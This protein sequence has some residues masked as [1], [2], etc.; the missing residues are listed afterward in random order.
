MNHKCILLSKTCQTE[1]TIHIVRF[2]L[3]DI[4]EKVKIWMWKTSV[5]VEVW[6]GMSDWLQMELHKE[7]FRGTELFSM[8]QWRWIHNDY[9]FFK[10]YRTVRHKEWTLLCANF[11]KIKQDV[12]GLLMECRLWQMN[13]T[14]LQMY[15]ITLL[16]GVRGWG[17]RSC[18]SNF[19]KHYFELIL[20]G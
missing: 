15:D 3:H 4:L 13:L 7:I 8:V 1:K 6:G 9:A 19:G 5:I 20:Q 17:E 12:G 18:Q 10:I 14:L 2:H 16:K 11:K